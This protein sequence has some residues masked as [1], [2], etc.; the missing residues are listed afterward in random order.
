[1]TGDLFR[2]RIKIENIFKDFEAKIINC[3]DSETVS[4]YGCRIIK[5]NEK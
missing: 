5:R 1:M 3:E 2:I 4:Y